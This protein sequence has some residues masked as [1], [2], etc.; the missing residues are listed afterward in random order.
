MDKLNLNWFSSLN[1]RVEINLK[2]CNHM[3]PLSH[4]S[5]LSHTLHISSMAIS[6][7]VEQG[8]LAYFVFCHRMLDVHFGIRYSIVSERVAKIFLVIV[9]DVV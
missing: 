5:I 6:H 7:C 1:Y 4:F 2:I 3:S 8:T 9:G